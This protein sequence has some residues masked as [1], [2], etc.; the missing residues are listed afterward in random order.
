MSPGIPT[1]IIAANVGLT[2]FAVA[3]VA[4]LAAD[5]PLEDIVIRA[6]IAMMVCHGVGYFVGSVMERALRD[7]L[8]EYKVKAA[9][10]QAAAQQAARLARQGVTVSGESAGG[11]VERS[12]GV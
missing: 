11:Q 3:L 6:M 8:Q 2:A 7:S 1:K 4:G 9:A 10:A 5:N 12:R